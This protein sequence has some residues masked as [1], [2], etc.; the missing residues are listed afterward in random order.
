MF[1]TLPPTGFGKSI[2][3]HCGYSPWGSDGRPVLPFELLLPGL[4]SS[5]KSDWSPWNGSSSLLN[6]PPIPWCFLIPVFLIPIWIWGINHVGNIPS[7]TSGYK[8]TST[9][10]SLYRRDQSPACMHAWAPRNHSLV[11]GCGHFLSPVSAGLSTSGCCQPHWAAAMLPWL[12]G[13]GQPLQLQEVRGGAQFEVRG[14]DGGCVDSILPVLL[15]PNT[16]RYL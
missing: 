14:V 5:N 15:N 8:L 6:G 1:I 10:R 12:R 9:Q 13:R 4:A 3:K 7:G 11:N 16:G 2:V